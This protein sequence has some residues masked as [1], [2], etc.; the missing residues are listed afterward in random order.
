M[1]NNVKIEVGDRVRIVAVDLRDGATDSMGELLGS[2][3]TVVALYSNSDAVVELDICTSYG[4]NDFIYRM[5]N[6]QLVEKVEKKK[7]SYFTGKVI[8]TKSSPKDPSFCNF[9]VGKVYNIQNGILYDDDDKKRNNFVNIPFITKVEDVNYLNMKN[10]ENFPGEFK[11]I[12]FK[13]FANK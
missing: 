7:P 11:F 4:V 10:E 6:L 5:K 1:S 12:E 2:Y 8:C 13:G 9:T 3:G